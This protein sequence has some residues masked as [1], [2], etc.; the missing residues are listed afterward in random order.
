MQFCT[1]F[2][3]FVYE[4]GPGA[5]APHNANDFFKNIFVRLPE[6]QAPPI[7]A[8][9][10]VLFFLYFHFL[11]YPGYPRIALPE[12]FFLQIRSTKK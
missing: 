6:V 9:Y 1:F 3:I 7:P 2:Q 5:R 10:F 4:H 11:P 8:L 12:I